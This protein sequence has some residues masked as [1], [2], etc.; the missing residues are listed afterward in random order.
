PE[1]RRHT[2]VHRRS[3]RRSH[4]GAVRGRHRTDGRLA[5]QS[6]RRPP[7]RARHELT[8]V[9]ARA[10]GRVNLIGE[11][12]DHSGGLVM[13][14][15]IDRVTEVEFER[16]VPWIELVSGDEDEPAFI[17]PSWGLEPAM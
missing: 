9:L 7:S 16:G 13:P 5:V 12:T 10:P 2:T 3:L 11:H 8:S 6:P 4:R 15:A 1:R 14:M 17:D